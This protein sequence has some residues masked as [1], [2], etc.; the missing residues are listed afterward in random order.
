MIGRKWSD[1]RLDQTS[2]LGGGGT[3]GGDKTSGLLR[4]IILLSFIGLIVMGTL[5]W[6]QYQGL[7]EWLADKPLVHRMDQLCR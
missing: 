1:D 2:S 3:L 6:L 4:A 7:L 5:G